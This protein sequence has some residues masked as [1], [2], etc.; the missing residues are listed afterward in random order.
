MML[1]MVRMWD[2]A[3]G[4]NEEGVKVLDED[5]DDVEYANVRSSTTDKYQL[6]PVMGMVN[7]VVFILLLLLH[8]PLPKSIDFLGGKWVRSDQ[9]WMLWR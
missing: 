4:G 6:W 1:T 5:G 2:G 8:T 3:R 9:R 7:N